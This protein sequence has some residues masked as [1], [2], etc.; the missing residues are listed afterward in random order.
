MVS[1]ATI[2]RKRPD[3]I[4]Y[5]DNKG[6]V[7]GA[8]KGYPDVVFAVNPSTFLLFEAKSASRNKNSGKTGAINALKLFSKRCVIF[9]TGAGHKKEF[10][11]AFFG[12]RR[13][14]CRLIGLVHRP[15]FLK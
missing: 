8:T 1:S 6:I 7:P 12:I 5:V 3:F 11:G 9:K 10:F 13:D 2:Q 4:V 14:I 15:L